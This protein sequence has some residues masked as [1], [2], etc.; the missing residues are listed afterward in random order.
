VRIAVCLS[1]FV[2][3]L[4][5]RTLLPERHEIQRQQVR[6]S[7]ERAFVDAPSSISAFCC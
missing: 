5:S 1:P 4:V 3:W 7:Y 6:R 2:T